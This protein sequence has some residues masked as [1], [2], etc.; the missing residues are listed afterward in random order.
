MIRPGAIRI[1]VTYYERRRERMGNTALMTWCEWPVVFDE[2][3][4]GGAPIARWNQNPPAPWYGR[5]RDLYE[6][7]MDDPTQAMVTVGMWGAITRVRRV[8][9]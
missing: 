8:R 2:L 7:S 5:Y 9:R 3:P 6:W 4:P 1:G